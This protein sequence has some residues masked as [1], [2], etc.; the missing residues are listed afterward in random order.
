MTTAAQIFGL[1]IIST[2]KGTYS[3]LLRYALS[4]YSIF[5]DLRPF[6]LGAEFHAIVFHLVELAHMLH[7]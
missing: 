1:I 7:V 5:A 3:Q 4:T 2:E 6:E